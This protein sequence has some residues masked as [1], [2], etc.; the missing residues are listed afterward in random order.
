M[1]KLSN[2]TLDMH[3]G[4]TLP[5]AKKKPEAL[6]LLEPQ[7]MRNIGQSKYRPHN[8]A[9]VHVVDRVFMVT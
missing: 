4:A 6:T 8:V 5:H 1:F 2:V 7:R 9:A 3:D